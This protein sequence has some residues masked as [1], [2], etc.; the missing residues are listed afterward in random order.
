M[1]TAARYVDIHAI[2]QQILDAALARF[3]HFGYN[4]TTMAE[5]AGDT[6]MSAANLYRYFRN[7][8]E[9]AAACCTRFI[10]DRLALLKTMVDK[11]ELSGANRVR[12]YIHTLLA[13][14][15]EMFAREQRIGELVAHITSEQP[16]IVHH[17]IELQ[18]QL[19]CEILAYGQQ[20]G[21]FEIKDIEQTAEGMHSAMVL[22]EV[23]MFINLFPYEVFKKRADA[24][25][26]ILLNGVMK[27]RVQDD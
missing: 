7:K 21:E 16:D 13:H 20:S 23:P 11:P 27:R 2:Q 1:N 24:V 3:G 15:Y 19:L 6:S 5:I 10:E 22:F 4:K 18:K 12:T 8:Q 9:I 25:A 14:N 26:D 17:R